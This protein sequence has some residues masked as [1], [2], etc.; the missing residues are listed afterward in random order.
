[1]TDNTRIALLFAA[2]A[3]AFGLGAVAGAGTE[4]ASQQAPIRTT[5]QF[6]GMFDSLLGT[7]DDADPA[8]GGLFANV[9]DYTD[10]LKQSGHR[11]AGR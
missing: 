2:L 5:H 10:A 11:A 3:G 9:L 1:M 8:D 7:G 4:A 6:D